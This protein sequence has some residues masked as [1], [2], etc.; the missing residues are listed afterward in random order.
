MDKKCRSL[1]GVSKIIPIQDKC[2]KIHS[3]IVRLQKTMKK[4]EKKSLSNT[5]WRGLLNSAVK[6]MNDALSDLEK[7]LDHIELE[8]K[9][10]VS[11]VFVFI[12]SASLMLGGCASFNEKCKKVW[13]SS[14]QHLE[15]VRQEGRSQDFGLSLDEAFLKVKKVIA[16]MKADIYLEN[17]EKGFLVAMNFKNHVDTTQAGIFFT[18]LDSSDIKIEVSSLSPR[19]VDEVSDKIF[20]ELKDYKR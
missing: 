8:L 15:D 12:F 14:I 7:R 5:A 2:S 10:V 19:L 6:G 17:K 4:V 16:S 18:S 3:K 20:A 13:G 1:H 9:E 11:I